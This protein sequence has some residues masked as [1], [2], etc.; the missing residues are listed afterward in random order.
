MEDHKVLVF[1]ASGHSKVAISILELCRLRIFGIIDRRQNVGNKFCGYDIIGS[2][3]DIGKIMHNNNVHSGIIA[4]GD[5]YVREKVSNHILQTCRHFN[6]INAI[7]PES[8]IDKKAQLGVGALIA[9]R[10]IIGP[11]SKIGNH[12]I[13]N[14]ASSLDHD[15]SMEDFS[16]LAPGVITGGQV[17]VG[18]RSFIGLNT[19]IIHKV[20]VGSDVV[21][22]AGSVV[23]QNLNP[24]AIYVGNPARF[25]RT[26]KQNQGYL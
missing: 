23:I 22:G 19:S 26:R 24:L 11:Y 1:G 2:D 4:I 8:I 13:L 17:I 21:V 9:A 15:S 18:K 10:A 20:N 16:S 14:T 25:I 5:N 12:C 3:D 7:H 6:F